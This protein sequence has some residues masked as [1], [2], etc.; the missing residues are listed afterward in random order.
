MAIV[1]RGVD[2]AAQCHDHGCIVNTRPPGT[3][4]VAGQLC[5]DAGRLV[6]GKAAAAK[7]SDKDPAQIAEVL[8][9][10][11]RA[12]RRVTAGDDAGMAVDPC[13]QSMRTSPRLEG[14][15]R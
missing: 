7:A 13:C 5:E 11:R 15:R 9:A 3:R 10:A 8:G 1:Q 12:A 4:D 14:L 2:L 6:V